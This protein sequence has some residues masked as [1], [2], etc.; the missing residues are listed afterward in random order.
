M[1]RSVGIM[2][3]CLVSLCFCEVFV[4][5]IEMWS[6]RLCFFVFFLSL[7]LAFSFILNRTR[8]SKTICC[9][10]KHMYVYRLLQQYIQMVLLH[11]IRNVVM[12]PRKIFFEKIVVSIYV[13]CFTLKMIFPRYSK[14]SHVQFAHHKYFYTAK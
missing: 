12:L 7:F 11:I 1:S 13:C 5:L 8:S 14:T 10:H 6:H 2:F 9:I 4:L 3:V